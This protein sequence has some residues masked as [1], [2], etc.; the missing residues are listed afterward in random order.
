[1]KF[2]TFAIFAEIRFAKFG[3]EDG[4]FG[5]LSLNDRTPNS[6]LPDFVIGMAPICVCDACV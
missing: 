2:N 4:V 6:V 3:L 1:M 5:G